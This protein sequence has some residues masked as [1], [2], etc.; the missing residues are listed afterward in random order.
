MDREKLVNAMES[1]R[2]RIERAGVKQAAAFGFA[3]RR[4]VLAAFREGRPLS[5]VIHAETQRLVAPMQDAMQAAHLR[6]VYRVG[7]TARTS[8]NR[9]ALS[10]A[11]VQAE[12]VAFVQRRLDLSDIELAAIRATYN[13]AVASF[14]DDMAGMLESK[15]SVAIAESVRK[16]LHVRDGIKAIKQA[17]DA[18]GVTPTNSYAIESMFRTQTAIAY[19][20]GRWEANQD[21]AIQEILWGYE[22]ATVGDDRVRPTHAA[23]DGLRRPKDDP[24]WQEIWPP[25][26]Y[27]CRCS[28]IEVFIGD[29]EA[30]PTALPD[31][32]QPDE[33]WGFNVGVV[34]PRAA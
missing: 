6:G 33:G 2:F 18:A 8:K 32:V 9:K 27:G 34:L 4:A 30:K 5:P 20:A 24:V 23:L 13:A 16:G 26:G 10:L 25:N 19:N 17:F 15:V 28:T 29:R 22:Y 14:T 3:I 12:A 1:E 7:M 31:V 11:N 21:P